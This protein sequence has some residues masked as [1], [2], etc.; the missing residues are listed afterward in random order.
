MA[1]VRKYRGKYVADYRDALKRRHIEA[2]RGT[3]K[4]KT[5]E[6]RAA[7]ELLRR[8]LG[9]IDANTYTPPNRETKFPAL[10]DLFLA[11]KKATRRATTMIDYGQLIE[12]YLKPMFGNTRLREITPSAVER[13]KTE[14]LAGIPERVGAARDERVKRFREAGTKQRAGLLK[15]G[16]R[17]VNKCL[18]LL[19]TIFAYA[20]RLE[21]VVRNPVRGVERVT[22]TSRKAR[23]LSPQLLRA[24]IDCAPDQYRLPIM[25]TLF[26]GCRSGEVRS[27]RW[28]NVDL[29]RREALIDSGYRY[30]LFTPTKTGREKVVELPDELVSALKVWKLACP[31][32]A[33]DLVFPNSRGT[34]PMQSTTLLNNLRRAV[35]DAGVPAGVTVHDLRHNFVTLLMGE[36]WSVADLSKMAGHSTMATTMRF[37]AHARPM[38]RV[39]ASDKLA[40]LTRGEVVPFPT[41][42]G[43]KM[44]T[45]AGKSATGGGAAS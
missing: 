41:T 45:S 7:E 18:T 30:G 4:D 37:Y 3:F 1:T 28:A 12:A 26:T 33:H 14:L 10:C 17:T 38:E 21:M 31:K 2:P 20:E 19:H 27:L 32:A 8:R 35:K 11:S 39:G 22:H 6:K 15:P 42:D 29:S 16:P 13:F 5:V 36:N 23:I 9:E 44:E 34:G 24:V 43:N 40:Q 25:F